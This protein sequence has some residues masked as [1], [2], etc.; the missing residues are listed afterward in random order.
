MNE[1]VF[2]VIIPTYNREKVIKRAIDSILNQTF[3]NFELIIVDDGSKDM[4]E[5]IVKDYSDERIVYLYKENG[6]QNSALNLGLEHVRGT[7]VAF[8][9]SDDEWFPTKLEKVYNKYLSD[10]E[11][12]VVYHLTGVMIDGRV[13]LARE[14]TFEGWIYKEVLLRGYLTS[15]TFISCKKECFDTIGEF[16]L[17]VTYWQDDDFCYNLCKY[18][19][20][21]LVKEILGIYY[22]DITGRMTEA[23]KKTADAYYLV[24]SKHKDD[25]VQLCG[26]KIYSERLCAVCSRYISIGETEKAKLILQEANQYD[27]QCVVKILEEM[28]ESV[29]K[30]QSMSD[31]HLAL[32]L[33]MNQWVKAKQKGKNLSNYFE[34]YGY[35]KI[36]IYGLSYAG[37][38]LIE[39]LIDTNIR[40]AY[41]I[42][43]RKD[44]NY[45]DVDVFTMED[46]MEEVDAVVV[47]AITSFAQIK[48]E[49]N[50]KFN[51]PILSLEN[52]LFEI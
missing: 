28:E 14:E 35:K 33:M 51:C 48:R 6:G 23:K 2:S 31:K 12:S 5:R 16:D 3:R 34:R 26:R 22:T 19:K 43:K 1:P 36:A 11:I 41:C 44:I 8:C 45:A 10:E 21:G 30:K 18:F 52:I 17:D 4:T 39:E 38:T 42:D 13:A 29:N 50:N 49:L 37:E 24:L 40:V 47:T 32:F 20:V 25:I 27:H 7:Y 46:I 15:P 9:D